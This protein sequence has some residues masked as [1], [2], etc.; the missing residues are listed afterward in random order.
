MF[1]KFFAKK[2]KIVEETDPDKI[3]VENVRSFFNISTRLAKY[4]CA[5][6]VRQGIFR[7]KYAVE[8]KNNDC[9]CTIKVFD[10]KE[11]IPENIN[12]FQCELDGHSEFSFNTNDLD[13][14]EYYQYI[15]N[16]RKST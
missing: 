14:V 6:A 7:K 8:C 10:T 3:Y 5:L 12:C 4:L 1:R 9:N 2:A 15:E 11:E 16:D 13:I